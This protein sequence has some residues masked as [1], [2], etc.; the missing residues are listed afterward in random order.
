MLRC[1]FLFFCEFSFTP[2]NFSGESNRA[3]KPKTAHLTH[4]RPSREQ[5]IS[6]DLPGAGI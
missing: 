6:A 2:V 1:I 3:E 4:R 5:G